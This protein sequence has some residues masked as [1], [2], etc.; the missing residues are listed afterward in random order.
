MHRPALPQ[1]LFASLRL[2]SADEKATRSIA[3]GGLA[4][5]L[6]LQ[7]GGPWPPGL[8]G[9]RPS[10]RRAAGGPDA[11]ASGCLYMY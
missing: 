1:T 6:E 9:G 4:G 8:R 2:C 10:W 7:R 11:G 3:S 5:W